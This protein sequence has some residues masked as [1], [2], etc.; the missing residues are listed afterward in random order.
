MQ[1]L[2]VIQ[3]DDRI[4][5]VSSSRKPDCRLLHPPAVQA[6]PRQAIEPRR[7]GDGRHG[8]LQQHV[9]PQVRTHSTCRHVL[10]TADIESKEWCIRR[11]NDPKDMEMYFAV[12]ENVFGETRTVEL[13]EGG[14]EI[15]VSGRNTVD[16]E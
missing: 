7:H 13:V 4:D 16:G 15:Q 2:S 1:S 5:V 14:A 12:D 11:E 6:D 9:V 10:E 3:Q 8:H